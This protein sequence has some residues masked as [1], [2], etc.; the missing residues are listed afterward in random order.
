MQVSLV[1][2][3]HHTAPV[4]VRERFA[5]TPEDIG[6]ALQELGSELGG[7][8]ILSTCNRTELYVATP[9]RRH[10]DAMVQ[11][12]ASA[13]GVEVP[14]GG[15]FYHR[16]GHD[17]VDHLFRVAAGLDSLVL[18]EYEILGQVRG[19]FTAATAAQSS[20]P[21]LA[22]LF[23]SAIRVGRRARN[24]TDI[25]RHEVSV[26]STAV[27]LTRNTLGDLSRRTVLVVGAGE[28]G[29]L[30]ARSLV[31]AGASRL[32]ITTRT[33]DRAEMLAEEMGGRALPFEER[34]AALAEADVAIT[35]TASPDHVILKDDLAKALSRRGDRPLV[36][37]DIAVPRDVEP[38]A[39]E[40]PNVRLFDI[41]ALQSA[42][43][44]NLELRRQEVVSV[45]KIVHEE[46]GRFQAWL[47]G[48]GAVPTVRALNEQA[49]AARLL[50]LERTLAR[51]PGLSDAEKRQI[52]TMTKALVKRLLHNPVT[53]LRDE[54]T[55][56]AQIEA[57]RN[58]FG[59]DE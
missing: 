20:N 2:I 26:G 21:A 50:E 11:A 57:A 5:F 1:G 45:E 13:R 47:R 56:P 6:P 55:D 23:H 43:E 36:I 49:E 3:S 37:V 40:L 33:F 54:N 10:E 16:H 15:G 34:Y 27:A 41:D 29:H 39:G 25:G 28:A 52:E 7:A 18:G 19:A 30:I 59:L 51:L 12:L 31:Q 38:S 4:A 14:E 17:A 48:L 22:R 9:H 44:A 24:E 53:R 46:A 32:L 8:A 35:S 58:L 42:A